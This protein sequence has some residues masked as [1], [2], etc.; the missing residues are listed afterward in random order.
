[1]WSGRH[2]DGTPPTSFDAESWEIG[3]VAQELARNLQEQASASTP[4]QDFPFAGGLHIT[5]GA[6]IGVP[7]QASH[8]DT[9][10]TGPGQPGAGIGLPETRDDGDPR[11]VEQRALDLLTAWLL[12]GE[13][14]EGIDTAAHIGILVPETTLM[15]TSDQPAITR[16]GRSI[17]PGP[18]IRDLLRIQG[19]NLT[20]HE[21]GTDTAPDKAPKRGSTDGP[22]HGE[23]ILSFRSIGRYPPPQLR[24]ALLFR[25]GACRADGCRA[26]AEGCDIDHITPWPRGSTTADNL[27]VLCRRHHRL[28]TAGYHIGTAYTQAA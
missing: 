24:A 13:G 18:H 5:D 3:Q 1:M 4:S 6:P 17:I 15:G 9:I 14:A 21:L 25:D 8:D 26:A 2:P 23:N 19:N 11:N 10:D 16:D 20:W 27:Q 12:T 28:K 7:H 22:A